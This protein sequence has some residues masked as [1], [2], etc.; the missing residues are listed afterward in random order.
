MLD[1]LPPQPPVQSRPAPRVPSAPLV[2]AAG[3]AGERMPS[4][5]RS[6]GAATVRET[7]TEAGRR[8]MRVLGRVHGVN[9]SKAVTKSVYGGNGQHMH[10]LNL[11][12]GSAA[13]SN[14]G[15]E[16]TEGDDLDV[17]DQVSAKSKGRVLGRRVFDAR[18]FK[19]VVDAR[20]T[21]LHSDDPSALKDAQWIVDHADVGTIF[22]RHD[23]AKSREKALDQ[24]RA[25]VVVAA[26]DAAD[27][28]TQE[29]TVEPNK[30]A[31]VERMAAEE[32]D[33][34]TTM[35][36]LA[37][38]GQHLDAVLEKS[39]L[40]GAGIG[41]GDASLKAAQ[42]ARDRNWTPAKLAELQKAA[43]H[44]SNVFKQL[45]GEVQGADM[46]SSVVLEGAKMRHIPMGLS[47]DAYADL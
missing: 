17:G 38:Y 46:D 33:L 25:G 47:A 8:A 18:N 32:S 31:D 10:P 19:A 30:F 40:E 16:L 3:F 23:E 28:V 2:L 4:G 26:D 29:S 27:V 43:I 41:W 37:E 5:L 11:L 34:V 20:K 44:R 9:G 6:I 15:R 1:A 24:R 39:T 14:N 42:E 21:L 7:R 36:M 12:Q 13:V 45:A 22:S 35:D